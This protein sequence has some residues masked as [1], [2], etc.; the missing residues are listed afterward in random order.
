M[1]P[2]NIPHYESSCLRTVF[3]GTPV[4]TFPMKVK[5]LDSISYVAVR[6]VDQEEGAVQRVLSKRRISSIKEFILSGNIFFNTFI[7]NWTEQSVEPT[8]RD[9]HIT[10]PLTLSAAQMIDGQHRLAGFQAAMEVTP[11]IGEKDVLVSLCIGLSTKQ[12]ATIFLNINS[13]QKPAPKSLIYDLFGEVVDDIDHAINRA[14]DIAQELNDNTDSPYY[15]AIKYPGM[16]R[17]VGIIDLSTVVSALR[18]H[19]EPEGVFKRIKLISLDRQRQAI[20]NY[21]IAIKSFYEKDTLWYNKTKNP[22]F[23]G[24]GFNGAMDYLTSTLLLKCAE[25]RSFSVEKFKEL[26]HLDPSTLL[27]HEDIKHLD[28]KTARKKIA[29]YLNSHLLSS[30]PEQEEYEF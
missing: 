24:A 8:F 11:E 27:L 18:P 25:A 2:A 30:L 14:N 13:E 22:F 16:P 7:L 20:L 28:G 3:S 15:K 26:L 5:D 17:G 1:T 21:F 23:K 4:F 6:G 12:A 19:L 29:E 9:G 10:V